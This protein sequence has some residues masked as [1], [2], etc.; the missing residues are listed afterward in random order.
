MFHVPE[1]YRIDGG[2][3][4]STSEYGNNGAFIIPV[5]NM[6]IRCIASDGCKWEHVSASL[7]NRCPNWAEMCVIKS[8]FWDEEDW[9]V[10]YHPAVSEYVS[11]HPYCL[12]LWRPIGQELPKP[13]SDLVGP[14]IQRERV[15]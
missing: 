1:R 12:H 13:P 14:K 4:G 15:S 8:I 3:Y 10:Q 11:Y 2:I 5:R 7:K 9:V 6:K